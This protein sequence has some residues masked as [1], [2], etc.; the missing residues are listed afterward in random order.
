MRFEETRLGCDMIIK[1]TSEQIKVEF[2][3]ARMRG[4]RL[5]DSGT[6]LA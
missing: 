1:A 3:C 2:A 4:V 6:S 5:A